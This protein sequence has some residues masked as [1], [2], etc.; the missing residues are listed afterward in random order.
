MADVFAVGVSGALAE[1]I[2]EQPIR[3]VDGEIEIPA[4]LAMG[5]T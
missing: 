2:G 5:D 4:D 3:P 1:D